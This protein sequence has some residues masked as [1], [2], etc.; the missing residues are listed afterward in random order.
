MKT[1]KE[2][3]YS[4]LKL[5]ASTQ[6]SAGVTTQYLAQSLGIIRTNVS[7]K[8]NELVSEGRVTKT[9]GR[10]V[11]YKLKTQDE[12]NKDQC[13]EN[14]IGVCGSLRQPIQVAKAAVIYPEKSLNTLILGEPGTGK[15]FL[16]MI[17][18]Q[19]AKAAKIIPENAPYFVIDCKEHQ[20]DEAKLMIE[21]FGDNGESGLFSKAGQGI[22]HIDNAHLLSSGLR[23]QF[24]STIEEYQHIDGE[25]LKKVSPMVIIACDNSNKAASDDYAKKLPIV[26]E[27]PS[28]VERPLE[29]RMA[30]IQSFFTLEAAR[31]KRTLVINAELL[32]CLLLYDCS[33]NIKQLKGDIKRGCAMAYLREHSSLEETLNVFLSDFEPYVRKGFLNYRDHR[34]EVERIIP[35]NYSY[36]FS[37]STM[38]M[39]SI[40]RAKLKSSNLYDEMD[41]KA[42][43]LVGLGISDDE[44]GVLLTAEFD[45]LFNRYMKEISTQV[46]NKEQLEKLV[47][48]RTIDL[49]ES[50]LTEVSAKLE[51][52]FPPSVFYGLCLHVESMVKGNT[53][54][55]ILTNRQITEIVEK[56]KT[57]Y[58]L[59]LQFTSKIENTY[60]I[61]LPVEE[62]FLITMFLCFNDPV[63]EVGQKPV[64]LFAL[65]GSGV[66]AS[67]V[68]LINQLVKQNNAFFYEVPFENQ[69]SETYKALSDLVKRIDRGKG[70]IAFYDT[71][72]VNNIFETI[73]IETN[74]EIRTVQMP[75]TMIGVEWARKAAVAE[76]VDTLYQSIISTSQQYSPRLERVIVTLC[77][78]GNGGALELKKYIEK[79]GDVHNMKIVPLAVADP[80]QFRE[81]L[82]L[83]QK[84]AV[85]HCI[86]GT[87]D[88]RLFGIP[89]IS[90][91]DV[92]GVDQGELPQVL[93]FKKR[94]KSRINFEEVFKYLGEQLD[95]VNIN[96]LRKMLPQ[97][98]DQINSE[99]VHMSIDT[100]IGLLMHIACS[101]NR[102]LS[103]DPLPQNLRK[104][105]ILKN[106]EACYKKLLR[107]L[108]PLEH[109]FDIIFTDDELANIIMIINKL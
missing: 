13:F 68:G 57:K 85:I 37:E 54:R 90:V 56:H 60:S 34:E 50:F 94:D 97:I 104:D 51:E 33:L 55:Q 87:N 11:L 38:K 76:D 75:I 32:R 48:P 29:E 27:L 30:I 58:S 73:E 35:E 100:E 74:I 18:H 21:L 84:Q 98:I 47:N 106:N 109:Y 107:V 105:Q 67:L 41:R 102:I 66:A 44:I 80:E 69:P 99:V 61:N 92:L 101:I 77:T 89:F 10:P 24:C 62:A 45:T 42:N 15:S 71:E 65:L 7:S 88:P 63:V 28:L 70:L 2:Q 8:L 49:V 95:N 14:L 96:K 93:Q 53:S 31:A 91:S 20:G 36:A 46:V 5:H 4:F 23:N 83:L 6:E 3:I 22:L 59:S 103:K 82:R 1:N 78:T 72:F 12:I 26:I 81:N 19:Y 52:N 9:N 86:V 16:A 17:M 39:S 25:P 43:A 40:D 108:K 79:H 64:I